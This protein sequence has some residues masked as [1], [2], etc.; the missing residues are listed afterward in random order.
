MNIAEIIKKIRLSLGL[1]QIAFAEKIHVCFSTVNHWENGHA[2]PN[3]LAT[4]MLIDLCK[5]EKV[6]SVLI[7]AFK[8]A[9]KL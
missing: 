1:S 4:I 7:N 8:E 6:S 9:N 2:K 3:R 5:K